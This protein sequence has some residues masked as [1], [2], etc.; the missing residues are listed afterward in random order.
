MKLNNKNFTKVHWHWITILGGY[1]R[2]GRHQPRKPGKVRELKICSKSQGK[3]RE[4][5]K[6]MAKSGK[7]QGFESLYFLN[8]SLHIYSWLICFSLLGPSFSRKFLN[9]EKLIFDC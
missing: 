2:Q 1:I 3:V 4:F 9:F 5:I 6:K 8:M 7:C